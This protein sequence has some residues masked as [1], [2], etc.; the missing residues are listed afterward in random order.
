M[1][2]YIYRGQRGDFLGGCHEADDPESDKDII[3]LFGNAYAGKSIFI[4]FIKLRD[5]INLTLKYPSDMAKDWNKYNFKV[6]HFVEFDYDKLE[7]LD[8][9]KIEEVKCTADKNGIHFKAPSF[10]VYVISVTPKSGGSDSPSPKTSD[11]TILFNVVLLTLLLS[12]AG[13]L[14]VLAK[15]RGEL[16]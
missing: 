8:S 15:R 11:A 4:Q 1:A 12:T 3:F 16:V 7:L 9:P 10:S 5:G 14:G 13:I 6:Y 2:E